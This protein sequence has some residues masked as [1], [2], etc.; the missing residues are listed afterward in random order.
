M[1]QSY[2]SIINQLNFNISSKYLYLIVKE[3]RHN[4]LTKLELTPD[5]YIQSYQQDISESNISEESTGD[6]DDL[7]NESKLNFKMALSNDELEAIYD[8]VNSRVYK[9]SDGK[10]MNREYR[11]LKPYEWSQTIHNYFYALTKLPCC[12]SYKNAFAKIFITYIVYI[13]LSSLESFDI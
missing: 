3:N 6:S 12:I 1:K 10:S 8:S 5:V 7:N 2:F 11:T 9:R 13:Y 4:I